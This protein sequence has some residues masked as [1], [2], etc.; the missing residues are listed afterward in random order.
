MLLPLFHPALLETTDVFSLHCQGWYRL[1]E[2]PDG[3]I[4]IL[5]FDF[6]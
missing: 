4:F 3:I 5:S 1:D 6:S 2:T